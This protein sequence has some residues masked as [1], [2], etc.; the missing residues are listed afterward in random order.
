MT[1]SLPA[2]PFVAGS[3]ITDPQFFVGRT[4]ELDFITSRMAAAQPTSINVVGKH[5]I[6]KSSLLFYFFL[7]YEQ[8][9]Q[10]YGKTPSNYMVIY[11]SLQ[12]VQCRQE[13][14]FYRAVAQELLKRPSVQ[15]N[16]ALATPL[17]GGLLDRQTFSAAIDAWKSQNVLPVLCLD[18]FEE[19]LENPKE[20]DNG[21][22]DNLRSLMD[23]NALML[24]MASHKRLDIYSRQHKLTSSFFN[25]GS[26]LALGGLTEA[27]AM[28]L[29]RLPKTTVSG[30]EAALREEKQK[31]A[32]E[33]AGRHPYL[34]Q[35]AGRCLW[36]ARQLD[37]DADWARKQFEQEAQ[38]L[39]QNQFHHKWWHPLRWLVWDIPVRLGSLAKFIG[40]TVDEVKSWITGLVIL[41]AMILV[42][43]RVVPW[44]R[45]KDVFQ[46]AM[47]G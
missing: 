31:L 30:E 40:G 21:F 12:G 17:N 44:E 6:G 37:R 29:V 9:V 38:R 10:R 3:M 19:L 1:S 32:I 18:K 45:V 2:C 39:P 46:K 23:R 26:V 25:L 5:R 13:T 36:E 4:E 43:L 14:S 8:R 42:V 11:L 16:L 33:W 15:A 28:D 24:V 47:G 20:F 27:E 7:T 35:L 22:Y 41:T 34:L